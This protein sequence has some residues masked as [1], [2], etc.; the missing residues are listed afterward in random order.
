MDYLKEKESVKMSL[1]T[2][3]CIII[4]IFLVIALIG[5]WFYF[6][7]K[8]DNTQ[9]EIA[10]NN[11][12]NMLEEKNN[13]VTTTQEEVSKPTITKSFSGGTYAYAGSILEDRIRNAEH[14]YNIKFSNNQFTADIGG[15]IIK[16]DYEVLNNSELK[17]TLKSDMLKGDPDQHI[18]YNSED[19]T[20]I[21]DIL[22]DKIKVKELNIPVEEAEIF[23]VLY[24]MFGDN[25][26]LIKYD[27]TIV[28]TWNTK[29]YLKYQIAND[30]L[31]DVFGTSSKYGSYLKLLDSNKFE[32]YVYPVTEGDAHRKGT[33]TFDGINKL[34]LK[35][36][37]DSTYKVE[38]YLVDDTNLLYDDGTNQ[39]VLSK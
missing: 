12:T 11:A 39:F 16:G 15:F 38:V 19:W 21:F 7:K 17:C 22:N 31:S 9:N 24:N 25:Q 4:I 34:T 20:I 3:I 8:E 13:T 2:L 37:D 14:Q 5:M 1:S 35:Y 36:D 29:S 26:E 33:Y 18:N 32:D 6:N 30:N 27:E 10:T 28:G 23:I